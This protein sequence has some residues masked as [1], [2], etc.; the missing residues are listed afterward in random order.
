MPDRVFKP[1]WIHTKTK[2][3]QPQFCRIVMQLLCTLMQIYTTEFC[4][5][6]VRWWKQSGCEALFPQTYT[7]P[8]L[9]NCCAS[10]PSLHVG[11]TQLGILCTTL[12][13]CGESTNC[14]SGLKSLLTLYPYSLHEQERLPDASSSL[15]AQS[16]PR[17]SLSTS[18]SDCVFPL[19]SSFFWLTQSPPLTY[20]EEAKRTT[21]AIPT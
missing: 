14:I 10:G 6:L 9:L 13:I 17:L 11:T 8:T 3:F 20:A 18:Q 21:A 5:V 16:M 7:R 4:L 19:H 15:R 2:Y 1:S 12:R